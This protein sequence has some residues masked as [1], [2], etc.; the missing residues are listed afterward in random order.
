MPDLS[1]L[2]HTTML[3]YVLNSD[4]R[5]AGTHNA[6]ASAYLR[7][8]ILVTDKAIFEYEAA[9]VESWGLVEQG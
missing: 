3:A 2:S 8:F 4:F 5:G 6:A 1:D 7:G 9:K